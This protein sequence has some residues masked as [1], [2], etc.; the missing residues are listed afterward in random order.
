M[1]FSMGMDLMGLMSAVMGKAK[2]IDKT[3]MAEMAADSEYKARAKAEVARVIAAEAANQGRAGMIAVANTIGNRAAGTKKTLI[4]VVSEPNQY[5]GYT[6]KNKEKLYKQVQKEADAIADDLVE[7]RLK[8]NTG[9]A[10]FFLLPK[11]K[12]RSWHGD[13]TVTIGSHTF[14]KEAKRK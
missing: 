6:A 8:D 9:G 13:K 12:V 5:Y 7:G 14:Y 2:P 3:A 10:K 11:E 4:D 1:G